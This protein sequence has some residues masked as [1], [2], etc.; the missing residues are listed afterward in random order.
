MQLTPPPLAPNPF[1]TPVPT[2][3]FVPVS[4]RSAL[5]KGL[6]DADAHAKDLGGT[7]GAVIIDLNSGVMLDRNGDRSFPM[8]SVQRLL[9]ATV[10]YGE[11]DQGGLKLDSMVSDGGGQSYT[12]RNLVERMLGN[13]DDSATKMLTQTLGGIDALN[14]SIR[15]LGYADIVA[16]ADDGGVATPN[17]L[18]RVLADIVG[19]HLLK[20]ASRSAITAMLAG[21]ARLPDGLRAGLG[22]KAQLM[23]TTGTIEA[24]GAT[25]EVNDVGIAVIGVRQI[26][27]VAMLQNAKGTDAQLD[28]VLAD[29]A[30]AAQSAAALLSP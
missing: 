4:E 11:I 19:G 27:V 14:A 6:D 28:A 18:A 26:V 21:D 15:N 3:T 20:P 22:P 9:I 1:A 29:V 30:R 16:A 13:G 2:R 17:D 24:N 23:H 12:V 8:A 5:S 25:T 7:L 10:I